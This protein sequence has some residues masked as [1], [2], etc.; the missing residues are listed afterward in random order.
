[1]WEELVDAFFCQYKFNLDISPTRM[2]LQCMEM[3][4]G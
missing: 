4:E 3:K 2:D 1:M